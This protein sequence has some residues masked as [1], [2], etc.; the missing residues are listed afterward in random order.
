MTKESSGNE[1]EEEEGEET[2]RQREEKGMKLFQDI[3]NKISESIK[4]ET[5]HP[6][7][8]RERKNATVRCESMA[9]RLY[10][11]FRRR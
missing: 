11:K 2:E 10:D 8:H 6:S 7:N 1:E 4:L 9:S 3:G 5:D